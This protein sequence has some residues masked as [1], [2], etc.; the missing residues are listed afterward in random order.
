MWSW[1]SNWQQINIGS[2]NALVA[3]R[4]QAIT[5]DGLDHDELTM[6]KQKATR[7]ATVQHKIL[8]M[9]SS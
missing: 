2:G 6:K 1:G 3:N 7:A 5:N 9:L 4:I 8:A